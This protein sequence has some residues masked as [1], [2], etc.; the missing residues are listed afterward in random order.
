M[1]STV[2]TATIS[3]VTTIAGSFTLVS[4]LTLLGLS[5]VKE[6]TTGATSARARALSRVL[7][8]AIVP[9]VMAFL[10]IAVVNVYLVLQ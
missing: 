3:T 5:I 8:V 9:L 4:L 7:T 6:T 10:M 1:I 2:T